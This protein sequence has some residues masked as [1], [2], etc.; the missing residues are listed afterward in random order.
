MEKSSVTQKNTLIDKI[1]VVLQKARI[2]LEQENSSKHFS[3]DETRKIVLLLT[4]ECIIRR[5]RIDTL[6]DV[7][8]DFYG[9]EWVLEFLG[10]DYKYEDIFLSNTYIQL[11]EYMNVAEWQELIYYAFETFEYPAEQFLSMPV[12]KGIHVAS[13]KKRSQGIYYT[14][15]DVIDF[16]I[17]TCCNRYDE[18]NFSDQMTYLDCSCGT[19]VF[20]LN[21]V[22]KRLKKM[23][24]TY[25]ALDMLLFVKD[26]IWGIDISKIA[27]DNCKIAFMIEYLLDFP[28]EKSSSDLFWNVLKKNFVC[29]DST[30]ME[31]VLRN[32]RHFPRRFSCIIG[33]PPYVT[34]EKKGNLFIEF[35]NNMIKYAAEYSCSSLIVPLSVCYS[36]VS[37]FVDLRDRILQDNDATWYFYNFDRSPDSLFGDQVKTRNT[38]IF[39]IKG[40]DK[41][42]KWST[43]IQRWT[44]ENR[45]G[46]FERIESTDIT[47]CFLK[48]YIPKISV[49]IEKYAF[50]R[51]K[52]LEK[53]L[54]DMLYSCTETNSNSLVVNGTAYNWICAYDHIPPSYDEKGD[55]YI[56]D[57]MQFYDCSERTD[58]YFIIA[59]LSNR[60][61]YWYWTVI[62]DGFHLNSSFLKQLGFH[63]EYFSKE[64][65]RTIARIGKE[66]CKEIKKN[67]QVTYNCKK[68]IINY[69]H[70]PLLEKVAKV[71]SLVVTELGI[72]YEFC[73]FVE[74][75]YDQHVGCGRKS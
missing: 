43:N 24:Q 11:Q 31:E 54:S 58:L 46:L 53:K 56:P 57:S 52:T 62:G 1:S 68:C 36:Q 49:N 33:N 15:T 10:M 22:K 29:G 25:L 70:I 41:G 72:P 71:E 34:L 21:I 14:P 3:C 64:T 28:E 8:K 66:Y 51:I 4:L 65:Y 63:K 45:E 74:K 2:V 12:K 39:R 59:M 50:S 26:R 44:S 37:S 18:I 5:E 73:G 6:D 32:N 69:N 38:I 60:I 13:E 17:D 27:I 9:C 55:V 47:E 7:I 19:A 16:M 30:N 23:S 67:V 75:W 20:L 40:G 48:E 35:V 42:Q 61:T